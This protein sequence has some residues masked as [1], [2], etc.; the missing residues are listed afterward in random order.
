M[1]ISAKRLVSKESLKAS[2]FYRFWPNIEETASSFKDLVVCVM[3]NIE[4]N[5]RKLFFDEVGRKLVSLDEVMF[6]T[7]E[8]EECLGSQLRYVTRNYICRLG[9][10]ESKYE[11]RK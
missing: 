11:D 2:E 5:H 9:D 1:E 10:R 7:A 3:K 6:E 8:S 4:E